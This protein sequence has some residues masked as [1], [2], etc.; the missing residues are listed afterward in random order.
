MLKKKY[1]NQDLRRISGPADQYKLDTYS[2]P[3]YDK[4][5][6]G[7]V[8]DNFDVEKS[9][10]L[11]VFIPE[12]GYT[13][14]DPKTWITV[15]YCSPFAGS[16]NIV[17]NKND[18][19]YTSSQISYGWWGVPPDIGNQVIV[20][21]INGEPNRGI[22][23]GCL[24]QQYMNYSVP[25]N[26]QGKSNISTQGGIDPP[27][28]EYNKKSITSGPENVTRPVFL[29]LHQALLNQGL[30]TDP[31]RGPSDSSSTRDSPSQV[32]GLKTPRG[33]TFYIDDGEIQYGSDGKPLVVENSIQKSNS[34]NEFIRLR[35]RNGT[36][37]LINDT[38]GYV[39]INSKNGDSW[40][41]ISDQGINMYTAKTINMRAEEG[42][43]IRSDNYI[44]FESLDDMN[45]RTRSNFG[46]LAEQNLNILANGNNFNMQSGGEL[47]V[48]AGGKI[49]LTASGNLNVQADKIVRNAATILDNSIPAETA[50]PASVSEPSNVGG[51]DGGSI[52]SDE[53][54]IPTRE[55]WIGHP[56]SNRNIPGAITNG[57]D[58]TGTDGKIDKNCS[59]DG[60]L[61]GG[62]VGGKPEDVIMPEG[63]P[64]PAGVYKGVGYD[65]NGQPIYQLQTAVSDIPVYNS[66]DAKPSV[67]NTAGLPSDVSFK[68]PTELT[69]SNGGLEKIKS[70]YTFLDKPTKTKDGQLIVGYGHVIT[71]QE[72]RS[73]RFDNGITQEEANNLLKSDL[74]TYE[75]LIK[76]TVNVPLT[77]LQY[78]S[79]VSFSKNIGK[80]EFKKSNVP[81]LMNNYKIAEVQRE[82]QCYNDGSQGVKNRR[83]NEAGGFGNKD[84][85]LSKN[86]EVIPGTLPAD[87]EFEVEPGKRYKGAAAPSETNFGSLAGSDTQAVKERILQRESS[88]RYDIINQ[89][90]FLGGYQF[91]AAALE[92]TGYLK[93]GSWAKGQAAADA[94]G[95]PRG[96]Q[97]WW[98]VA[99]ENAYSEENWTGKDGASSKNSYL[100]NRTAQERAMDKLMEKNY[101]TLVNNGT[102]SKDSSPDVIA[103]ALAGSH[104][105]GA[106]SMTKY[107]KNGVNSADA[108]G[109][110]IS[111]YYNIGAKA[112]KS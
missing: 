2:K 66:D 60:L 24:Y 34:A 82:I 26:A 99:H 47:E 38:V 95:I 102:I 97:R 13:G 15:Q 14:A 103:G 55:P 16:T 39:Y 91:G 77:Q 46:L 8:K 84:Y 79:L 11:R 23:I 43:N 51:L 81:Q 45:L 50:T 4:V 59:A 28:V 58:T 10:R 25:E 35:T 112:V 30:Y 78:D 74:I 32:F 18:D 44:N 33:H 9:G 73:G 41:E 56:R 88:G 83:K 22:W 96:T 108:N 92:D 70:Y 94:A 109:T 80:D 61:G 105:K 54:L 19:S 5:Y 111:E 69:L 64:L 6:I 63:G 37:V 21:F 106:G 71:P 65:S 7:I 27:V 89:Y 93:P 62:F 31:E 29:P 1:S 110:R 107:I 17:L 87:A 67:E 90:G 68:P 72:A 48:L 75:Q 98:Q 100:Y 57:N 42:I 85:G 40:F 20:M 104:L 49:A 101:K 12:F 53:T 76:D 52:I 3:I 86:T 36:Q